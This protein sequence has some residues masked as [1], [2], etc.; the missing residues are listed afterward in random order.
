MPID[1]SVFEDCGGIPKFKKDDSRAQA[2][3]QKRLDNQKD[4]REC[5][6]LVH[7]R[8]KGKC[9]VP[10]CKERS[11]H[12]H[13][14]TYR[15]KGGKWRSGNI[16]SLCASHHSMVHLGKISISGDAD[17]ELFVTGDTAALRF[18]L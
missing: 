8:D 1:Y 3:R 18:K 15:S 13:H 2:R 9:V 4:E 5:R 6:E 16:C 12:L 11:E 7:K 10:G 14:I 17:Q